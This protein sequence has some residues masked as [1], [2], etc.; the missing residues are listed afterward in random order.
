[1]DDVSLKIT[2]K[3][4]DL[5][6]LSI[7]LFKIEDNNILY[8]YGNIYFEK[9]YPEKLKSKPLTF[10]IMFPEYNKKEV[11][12]N[13]LTI[14][15]KETI[16]NYNENEFVI[17][18]YSIDL[19]YVIMCLNNKSK[20]KNDCKTDILLTHMNHTIRTPLNG[21]SGM[22]SL[23]LN[24]ELTDE[25]YLYVQSISQSSYALVKIITDLLDLLKLQSN[26]I[27]LKIHPF[28]LETCILS[29]INMLKYK[30]DK[31]GI[32]LHYIIYPNIYTSVNGDMERFKQIL[33]NILD[34]AIKYTEKGFIK[35]E[36]LHKGTFSFIISDTGI[37]MTDSEQENI[38]KILNIPSIGNN[39]LKTIG[40]GI[41]ITKY[42]IDL[43]GGSIQCK[44]ILNKGTSFT[45]KIPFEINNSKN[46]NKEYNVLIF[47]KSLNQ[48]KNISK[49]LINNK[50]VPILVSSLEEANI[51]L[52]DPD[53][54]INLVI[55]DNESYINYF[56]GI[57]KI[58]ITNNNVFVNNPKE[59][60]IVNN[61][62][63]YD[64]LKDL[65]IQTLDCTVNKNNN[66]NYKI[67]NAEDVEIN[68]I[69]NEK[70]LLSLGYN[71]FKSL[72]TGLEVLT[73]LEN[74]NY[75]IILL[76]IKLPHLSGLEILS[77]LIDRKI[78]LPYT[79]IITAYDNIKQ[80]L[81]DKQITDNQVNDILIK[82]IKFE[83]LQLAMKKAENYLSKYEIL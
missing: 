26:N 54:N 43:M 27:S 64:M 74:N 70:M 49:I 57:N 39:N 10:E 56:E 24:S 9:T 14:K 79:I 78:K 19:K 17:S 59:L 23:L 55:L 35:L 20:N 16:F 51:F 29:V 11:V 76:D 80:E 25:Q 33:L 53:T 40:L 37:G 82:P 50:I 18:I 5:F 32:T 6:E 58:F 48:K 44:S 47:I 61:P 46:I 28:N 72:A 21:I 38:K 81:Y 65:I 12:N 60:Q 63:D 83:D 15:N 34:N 3:F 13:I 66:N 73:E 62:Y 7:I 30:A 4:F 71:N 8:N 52:I 36:V 45:I 1:M 68:R 42:L 41:P 31:K 2:K 69:V 22:V 75:D 67:L 77:T